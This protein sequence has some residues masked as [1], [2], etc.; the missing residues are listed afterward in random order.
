MSV[1]KIGEL[2]DRLLELREQKERLNEQLKLVNHEIDLINAQ[3][4][5]LM[6]DEEMPTFQRGGRVYY[7]SSRVFAHVKKD[8]ADEFHRWLREHGHG[9]LIR[10]TI[11]HQTLSA[12][13]KEIIE[14]NGALPSGIQEYV[15][16]FEKNQVNIRKR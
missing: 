16:V 3:L 7:L 2:A 4:A 15:S 12:W 5:Q 9:G 13:C 8:H 14:Q 6:I 11:P 1:T 10:E